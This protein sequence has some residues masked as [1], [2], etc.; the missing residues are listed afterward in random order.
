MWE[1]GRRERPKKAPASKGTDTPCTGNPKSKGKRRSSADRR[2]RQM[3]IGKKHGLN[4]SG[5]KTV[6]SNVW[7]EDLGGCGSKERHWTLITKVRIA[8]CRAGRR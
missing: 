3:G 4:G 7:G 5:K 8:I 6:T 1:P 2:K